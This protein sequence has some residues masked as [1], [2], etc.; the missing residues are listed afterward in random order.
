[1]D[2]THDISWSVHHPLLP[3]DATCSRLPDT[4][5]LS[6]VSLQWTLLTRYRAG[7]WHTANRQRDSGLGPR[8]RWGRGLYR[9]IWD[10][11]ERSTRQAGGLG[12]GWADAV[13]AEVLQW[14]EYLIIQS[15]VRHIT[16]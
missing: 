7:L 15:F 4:V 12:G 10:S 2:R 14:G 16:N 6:L 13:R 1:V 9:L 8:R 5:Q 3:Y 11:S